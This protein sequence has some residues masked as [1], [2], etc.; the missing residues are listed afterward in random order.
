MTRQT[1]PYR[2]PSVELEYLIAGDEAFRGYTTWGC[3]LVDIACLA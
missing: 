3:E 2:L 1:N